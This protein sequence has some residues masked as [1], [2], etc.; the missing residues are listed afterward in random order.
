[1]KR[2][3]NVNIEKK[4]VS[5]TDEEGEEEYIMKT[6]RMKKT[7]RKVFCASM[8]AIFVMSDMV[9]VASAQDTA[10]ETAPAP[11][12]TKQVIGFESVNPVEYYELE[13][14]GSYE[15]LEIPDKIRVVTEL[16]EDIQLSTFEEGQAPEQQ[17]ELLP[18]YEYSHTV[19][20]LMLETAEEASSSENTSSQA[21]EE[22]ASQAAEET[23]SQGEESASSSETAE[24][25]GAFDGSVVVSAEE[26]QEL[27]DESS[28]ISY[29]SAQVYSFTD[30][31]GEAHY[32]VYGSVD[33]K[34]PQWY[35]VDEN[36]V[37]LGAVEELDAT[38]DFSQVDS[39]AA[40]EYQVKV[41]LP[42]NYILNQGVEIAYMQIMVAQ[43]NGESVSSEN[44]DGSLPSVMS[45]S[46][47]AARSAA[48]S[49][50]ATYDITIEK[51]GVS[52]TSKSEFKGGVI[53]SDTV[54]EVA[55]YIF[56][57]E[58]EDDDTT[59]K[60]NGASLRVTNADKTVISYNNVTAMYPVSQSNGSTAWFYTTI[61]SDGKVAWEVPEGA[62]L[63]FRYEPDPNAENAFTRV[64]IA[65]EDWK[66]GS[67]TG[68]YED[69]QQTYS[70]L[71]PVGEEVSITVDLPSLYTAYK[72]NIRY[73]NIS[74]NDITETNTRVQLNAEWG[75]SALRNKWIN[76]T[77]TFKFSVPQLDEAQASTGVRIDLK[78]LSYMRE[79]YNGQNDTNKQSTSETLWLRINQDYPTLSPY[80]GN[81]TGSEEWKGQRAIRI[82]ER[83]GRVEFKYT[84]N[85][86]IQYEAN[87][88]TGIYL[89]ASKTAYQNLGPEA[90]MN[91]MNIANSNWHNTYNYGSTD[92]K[93]VQTY[94][95]TYSGD[96]AP[97]SMQ[98][99]AYAMYIMASGVKQSSKEIAADANDER[100]LFF[101]YQNTLRNM[102]PT[103]ST[104][105]WD[106]MSG[107][108]QDLPI[109]VMLYTQN[110]TTGIFVPLEATLSLDDPDATG[111]HE[112]MADVKI[113]GMDVKVTRESY[114]VENYT[115]GM[116]TTYWP[117]RGTA[118]VRNWVYT[119]QVQ[120][121]T[122]YLGADFITSVDT[123][124]NV[125]LMSVSSNIEKVEILAT[126]GGGALDNPVAWQTVDSGK[127]MYAYQLGNNRGGSQ[128]DPSLFDDFY[129]GVWNTS[130]ARREGA[131]PIRIK[132]KEGYG[133]PYLRFVDS[134]VSDPKKLIAG[135][136]DTNIDSQ[137]GTSDLTIT[138]INGQSNKTV[139]GRIQNLG[140]ASSSDL[141][142]EVVEYLFGIL[143]GNNNELGWGKSVKFTIEADAKA[144]ALKYDLNK[145]S[146]DGDIPTTTITTW[147]SGYY[148]TTPTSTPTP[149]SGRGY[150]TGWKIQ[151]SDGSFLQD[152]DGDIIYLQPNQ[153][154]ATTDQTYF[155][156]DRLTVGHGA[157]YEGGSG[158]FN[159][160]VVTLVADYSDS[161]SEGQM[162]TGDVIYYTQS[163]VNAAASTNTGYTVADEQT[164]TAPYRQSYYVIRDDTYTDN[165]NVEYIFNEPV[166]LYSG[167]AGDVT[168]DS[169]TILGK[170][171]YDKAIE[172]SYDIETDG[173]PEEVEITAP[174][175][176][177]KYTTVNGNQNIITLQTLDGLT[178]ES[179]EAFQGWMVEGDNVLIPKT[180]TTVNL[181][182]SS[183]PEITTISDTT[184]RLGKSVIETI[185][186]SGQ[187]KFNAVWET[188]KPIAS[189]RV[190]I[191]DTNK[192]LWNNQ[193]KQTAV[194]TYYS[195]DSITIVGKFKYD[196][197][198]REDILGEWDKRASDSAK[199]SDVMAQYLD[200]GL[201]GLQ[202]VSGTAKTWS[203]RGDDSGGDGITT[204]L[205]LESTDA[206][207]DG[208]AIATIS[209]TIPSAL[210]TYEDMPT[211][212]FYLFAWNDASNKKL[213]TSYKAVEHTD[214]NSPFKVVD[215]EH[216]YQDLGGDNI[217]DG[218]KP[219]ASEFI[220]YGEMIPRK[221]TLLDGTIED[222][223][224]TVIL[225]NSYPT[226]K[227]TAT[228][229]YDNSIPWLA[230]NV[231]TK[232]SKYA[233]RVAIYRQDY[234]NT[235]NTWQKVRP[236]N[237]DGTFGS[238]L[239]SHS[240][241]VSSVDEKNGTFTVELTVS[242]SALS[243]NYNTYGSKY[244]IAA[245]NYDNYKGTLGELW[246]QDSQGSSL[247][248]LKDAI[249]SEIPSNTTTVTFKPKAMTNVGNTSEDEGTGHTF[250]ISKKTN[251]EVTGTFTFSGDAAS[252]TNA[253]GAKNE[254]MENQFS[255]QKGN[256]IFSLWK[257]NPSSADFDFVDSYT[258]GIT[259]DPTSES[260]DDYIT[261][262]TRNDS[263]GEISV[264]IH[265]GTASNINNLEYR[266]YAWYVSSNGD[267]T[268][269]SSKIQDPAFAAV[270][271]AGLDG[272]IPYSTA[273]L[274][275]DLEEASYY[276][277]IP[278][279]V[280]L[281]DDLGKVKNG[282]TD[283]SDDYAGN[284]SSIS[285]KSFDSAITIPEIDVYLT[286]NMVM[287]DAATGI[288]KPGQTVGIYY[289]DGTENLDT[290]GTSG[291]VKLGRLSKTD[292]PAPDDHPPVGEELNFYL[293]T[294]KAL[295]GTQDI[296]YET[297]LH[298]HFIV[299]PDN[300]IVTT[301][302]P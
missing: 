102:G 150:F 237:G 110:H 225:D 260:A 249:G 123:Q 176:S 296:L 92:N 257:R 50:A 243:A 224:D 23:A 170:L 119:I 288:E 2:K 181:D 157:D 61:L 84:N 73:T 242:A 227:L 132:Q 148:I 293:N 67:A 8:A 182:Y 87:P 99:G 17:D 77:V 25:A 56:I 300:E 171:Y 165:N 161:I 248:T 57:E 103:Y 238:W 105:S 274:K 3:H 90:L 286:D 34:D 131:L 32:R 228:F 125:S 202:G 65:S 100:T 207:G 146:G 185:Y 136:T 60:S 83:T 71:V 41:Q 164:T 55:N 287:R 46:E 276:I 273:I 280:Q 15:D 168:D 22:T 134:S 7:F 121:A 290:D 47:I 292:V 211:Q 169:R 206:D 126:E 113:A 19:D 158:Y 178:G 220:S 214:E 235:S 11:T 78:F 190:N 51:E 236:V 59:V 66:D 263:T 247:G 12:D 246:T 213:G 285:Y 302:T 258:D 137:T 301:P 124:K 272:V 52:G 70:A 58:L 159:A 264:N 143:D 81:G 244:K 219:T 135:I 149:P 197:S 215:P 299:D 188:L 133:I 104:S 114:A 27:L 4:T 186:E 222:D 64:T 232:D 160:S 179:A 152:S 26:A 184:V 266:V 253:D 5:G 49:T 226:Q 80:P 167:T 127:S 210:V 187:V 254:E 195:G 279:T 31:K 281:Y 36:G 163:N 98:N 183:A 204:K 250:T 20:K 245:Y 256:V 72:D 97:N 200:W 38:W 29:N 230:Q 116:S 42:E 33:E 262:V 138:Q 282:N 277:Q 69:G 291:M 106:A 112:I 6:Q 240:A 88:G 14:G 63:V 94:W 233:I 192:N 174:T 203:L 85:T 196:F 241:M 166:S 156:E 95:S 74:A 217:P 62:E 268:W 120:G 130:Y 82:F 270:D 259:N 37:V 177:N 24:D 54:P 16:P 229:K 172:V 205:D 128:D 129:D 221:I 199:A 275:L 162:I 278:S 252:W 35:A 43:E 89:T 68:N 216:P 271:A 191:D 96:D 265:I 117:G 76:D 93:S 218:K 30:D 255:P 139:R 269:D 298:F 239:I 209:I 28:K 91:D 154:I 13:Y 261:S 118:K 141:D 10:A 1:M 109:G 40:G 234:N 151:L 21:T 283:L 198:T 267:G 115:T 75:P 107:S 180:A 153:T 140:G 45:L 101:V 44:E 79:Y 295:G 53:K 251:G 142:G 297:T 39:S 231:A 145:G 208:Y 48:N 147:G 294:P 122:G 284:S 212:Q 194:A 18:K 175:D 223:P 189:G 155:P 144:L 86:N 9:P 108:G 289:W 173:K 193:Y 201:Y 111:S